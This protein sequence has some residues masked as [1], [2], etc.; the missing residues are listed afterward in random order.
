M[1]AIHPLARFVQGFF[2][3]YLA[4]QRGLSP[5]TIFS[6]RDCLKLFLRFASQ[7]VG[8]P[9]DKLTLEDFDE[10][11]VVAFLDDLEQTRG[12]ST[13]TR[14]NRLTALRA[15]FRYVAGQEPTVLRRCQRICEI[16]AKRTEHKTIEYLEDKEMT[17]VLE[18]VDQSSRNG[19][20]D[21]ALLMFF[22]NSGARVQEVVDLEI[23]DVRLEAPFQVK[24]T[25]KGRKQRVCPLWPETVAAIH[26]YLDQRDPDASEVPSMFLNA[27][28]KPITR[29]GIRYIVRHYAAKAAAVCPSVSSKKVSPHSIRH[30]TAMHLLQSGN[31]IDVVKGWLGHADINTTHGY[32]EIDMKMKRKA[33]EACQPPKVKTGAK[34]RP[35]WQQPSI[36]QW[37][38]ELSKASRN[39][40]Q[41]STGAASPRP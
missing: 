29:F 12:N 24:L 17:A 13:Q 1:N 34:H 22:Y 20:R 37:L 31:S 25:G 26:N 35:K 18:S 6:Y 7:R 16:P 5:N 39:Y 15:F 28:G 4:A 30:T 40:V 19:L 27:N 9:V 2:H 14:N 33:L 38:D 10:K 36:L 23:A 11:L 3:E 32:V 8:K 21:Y 41:R